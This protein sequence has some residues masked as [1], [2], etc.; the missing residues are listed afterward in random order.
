MRVLIANGLTPESQA[1]GDAIWSGV[2]IQGS[3][4]LGFGI[5]IN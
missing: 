2:T 5:A 3:L 4:E 1:V